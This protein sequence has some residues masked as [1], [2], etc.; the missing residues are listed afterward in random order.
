MTNIVE[1]AD[2]GG[3]PGTFASGAPEKEPCSLLLP[4]YKPAPH[5]VLAK[6]TGNSILSLGSPSQSTLG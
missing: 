1:K 5:P 6:S 3:K 4:L 2:P